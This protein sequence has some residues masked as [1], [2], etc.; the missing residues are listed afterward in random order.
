MKYNKYSSEK[1]VSVLRLYCLCGSQVGGISLKDAGS[2]F[3]AKV[4]HSAATTPP[5]HHAAVTAKLPRGTPVQ[6]GQTVAA[7]IGQV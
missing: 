6:R 4:F 5:R 7:K 3:G 1:N 2:S